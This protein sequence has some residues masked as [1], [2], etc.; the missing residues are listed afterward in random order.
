MT[1][2]ILICWGKRRQDSKTNENL[3]LYSNITINGS[4]PY[5]G[6]CYGFNNLLHQVWVRFISRR[7]R[8]IYDIKNRDEQRSSISASFNLLSLNR[9]MTSCIPFLTQL[10]CNWTTTNTQYPSIMQYFDY[11]YILCALSRI[12]TKLQ[13]IKS[14]YK[15]LVTFVESCAV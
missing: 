15:N 8:N 13:V 14:I 1:L 12:W 6:C 7:Q 5:F 3:Q 9:N 10:S 4:N 11:G 2:R